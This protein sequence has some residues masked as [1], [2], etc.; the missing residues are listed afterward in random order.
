MVFVNRKIKVIASQNFREYEAIGLEVCCN[1]TMAN[2]LC[3][4]KP[5]NM[6]NTD[7]IHF[8]ESYLFGVDLSKPL[9]LIGDLNMDTMSSSGEKLLYFIESNN[10]K[11]AVSDY[12][13]VATRQ[14]KSS[15][16]STSKSLI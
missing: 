12:T 11:N 4:Y 8:F 2:F 15:I 16:I 10:L 5:P 3:Y 7:F 9:F 14:H 1:N 13:R 6:K